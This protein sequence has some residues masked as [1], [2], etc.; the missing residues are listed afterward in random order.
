MSSEGW[1][2]SIAFPENDALPDKEYRMSTKTDQRKKKLQAFA[3]RRARRPEP[4]L[5]PGKPL[6]VGKAMQAKFVRDHSDLLQ[7]IEF[8][9]VHAARDEPDF[10][11]R[12]AEK[13]LRHAITRTDAEDPPINLALELLESIRQQRD[14]E[15]DDLWGDALRVIYTSLKHHSDCKSGETSYLE[16]ISRYVH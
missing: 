14:L 4:T 7:N 13:I 8:M 10:D 15:S 6:K 11:D 3:K 2:Q 5:V 12:S 9:L 16:F 1:S